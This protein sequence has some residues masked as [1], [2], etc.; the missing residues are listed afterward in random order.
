[1]PKAIFYSI[2]LRGTRVLSLQVNSEELRGYHFA[3]LDY[4]K[5]YCEAK[6]GQAAG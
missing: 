1:M 4:Y 2:Y 6:P 5:E 3:F